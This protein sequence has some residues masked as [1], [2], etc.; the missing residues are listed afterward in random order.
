MKDN[1]LNKRMEGYLA[2]EL[3]PKERALFG[4]TVKSD[5][6]LRKE[7]ALRK[8]TDRA[9]MSNDVISLRNKL[10]N[11]EREKVERERQKRRT[12]TTIYKYAAS[13][14]GIALIS[15]VI[16]FVQKDYTADKIINKYYHSYA[17]YAPSRYDAN[18]IDEN[19]N[20]AIEYYN[21]SDYENAAIYFKKVLDN[22]VKFIE[23]TM[24]LGVSYFENKQY[25]EATSSF[26]KVIQ[27]NNNL[28]I[29]DANWYLALCYIQTND[30]A[31][32]IEQL[33]SIKNSN[34]RYKKDAIKI[35]RKYHK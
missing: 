4:E 15:G 11:I 9:L 10:Q 25:N 29:E 16:L 7:L 30:R 13:F 35:I 20:I 34:S 22:N 28:F 26:E 31:K 17:A 14:I 23:S 3:S 33:E 6:Q 12:L 32:A 27:H 5:D 24:M 18:E 1:V 21:D 8:M 2:G 19:Y